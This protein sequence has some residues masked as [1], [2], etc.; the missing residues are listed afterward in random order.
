[1]TS[2]GEAATERSMPLPCDAL[3]PDA[4]AVVHRAVDV[5]APAELVFRWLCQLRVAPYSYD[6][7]DNGGRRS[8]R[9]L[10]PGLEELAEGQRVCRIF[11]L[12]SFETGRSLTVVLDDPAGARAFGRV[13]ITWHVSARGVRS[14]RLLARVRLA[15]LGPVRRR[16]LLWG[17][18]IM[19]RKQLRTLA[20]LA[21]R[22]AT[23]A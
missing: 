21:E 9:R 17:D 16:A 20:A 18:L 11:R 2:W 15:G 8:P 12:A 3:L 1:V 5:A 19:M 13:A 4:D 7:L 22:D 10:T 23:A 14:A 6:L